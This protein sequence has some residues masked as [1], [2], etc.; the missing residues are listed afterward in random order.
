ML[1]SL[2]RVVTLNF[3][4]LQTNNKSCTTEKL[5]YNTKEKDVYFQ[6]A[7]FFLQML[8]ALYEHDIV[9]HS[10]KKIQYLALK[11]PSL[12][13]NYEQDITNHKHLN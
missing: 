9:L 7:E 5:F 8:L 11:S 4:Q 10:V 1:L 13:N 2:P 12:Q 3:T 6:T